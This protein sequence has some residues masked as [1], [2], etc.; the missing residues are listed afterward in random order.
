MHLPENWKV[1]KAM[2]I[3][4]GGFVKCLAECFFHADIPNF[5]K[6]KDAFPEYWEKYKRIAD[7]HPELEE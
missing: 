3:Y 5:H 6:L 2:Q 7:N 1:A 4:G